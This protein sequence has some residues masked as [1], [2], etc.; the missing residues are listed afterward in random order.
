M[1][2]SKHLY[3]VTAVA[4]IVFHPDAPYSHIEASVLTVIAKH[5]NAEG[6]CFPGIDA[7]A[8]GSHVSRR[9]V[10]TVLER[11]EHDHPR[12]RKGKTPPVAPHPA[13]LIDIDHQRR[14][15]RNG[16]NIY[17]LRR[18]IVLR[19]GA[20]VNPEWV[21]YADAQLARVFIAPSFS[22]EHSGGCRGHV[23]CGG[24]H[25]VPKFLHD[26]FVR[27]LDG[28]EGFDVFGWYRSQ[29]DGTGKHDGLDD[30]Q[31]WKLRMDDYVRGEKDPRAKAKR[32]N[33]QTVK[34]R[35]L[36]LVKG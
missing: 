1:P 25:H 35:P 32:Q 14:G 20:E 10:L 8:R 36:K 7:V 9:S 27:R 2:Q 3:A 18:R 23:W 6:K 17:R 31:F 11:Q 16:P 29:D 24:L 28:A 33:K 13:P 12:E 5:M 30:K 22:A 15:N 19:P 26:D 4:H 21:K 34:A